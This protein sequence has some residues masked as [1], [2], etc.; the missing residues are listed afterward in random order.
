MII[1]ALVIALIFRT[2]LYQPFSI[3]TASMQSTL[4][5]GDYFIASKFTWGF[6]KYS[7]PVALPFNGRFLAFSEPQRGDV[8]VFRNITDE[9]NLKGGID[10]NNLTG[11]VNEPRIFGLTFQMNFGEF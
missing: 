3:P 6:G 8:A 1:E 5:I 7:F 10:F 2:F 4:M 11:F 9:E